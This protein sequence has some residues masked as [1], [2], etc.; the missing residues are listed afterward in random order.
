MEVCGEAESAAGAMELIAQGTPDLV[1]VDLALKDS[2][3]M[4]LIKDA[5]ARFPKLLMLV[6][7]MQD[8]TLYAEAPAGR[9]AGIHHEA[10]GHR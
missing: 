10:R 8:E 5:H 1:I 6:L 7:S 9:G 2:N 3:G 4:D